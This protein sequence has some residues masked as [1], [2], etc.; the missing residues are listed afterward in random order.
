MAHRTSP[1]NIGLYLLSTLAARDLGWIGTLDASERLETTME[2][3]NRLELCRGHFYN[4][5][6]T[7]TLHPLDPKYVSSVDSGN[8]A[9]H[10]LVVGNGCRELI[11]QCSINGDMFAGIDDAIQLLRNALEK[12]PD[13]RQTHTVTMKQLSHAVEVLAMA[14]LSRPIDAA[15][16]TA[17]FGKL[18][19]LS[20]TVSD[21]A[22]ALSQECG[23]EPAGSCAPGPMQPGH[24]WKAT[25]GMW[26]SCYHGSASVRKTARPCSTIR[27]A[28]RRSGR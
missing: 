7:R 15:G 9:G 16:W 13:Q 20:H 10:L 11:Q 3:M 1:T 4:W 8:L 17:R 12:I 19:T 5:Y 26:N 22:Q 25:S 24:A 6:D 18:T 14:L 2:T 23:D 21:M 27:R 28:H